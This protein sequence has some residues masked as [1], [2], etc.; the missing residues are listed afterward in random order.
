M[1][2]AAAPTGEERAIR[3]IVY[4]EGQVYVAQ[5]LEYD[6]AAQ[7]REIDVAIERLELTIDADF[8]HCEIL[9]VRPLDQ[10]PPA[11]NYFHQLWDKKYLTLTRT[12]V[13]V[14]GRSIQFAFAK[15]A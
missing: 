4:R 2:I 9:G 7:G 11:Q 8:S 14:G 3:V 13:P 5:C 15:A 10:I 1:T 6:I 12:E